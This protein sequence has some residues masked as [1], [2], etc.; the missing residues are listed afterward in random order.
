MEL[1]FD[2]QQTKKN[3]TVF[4]K[5]ANKV[6]VLYYSSLALKSHSRYSDTPVYAQGQ[7][8][9][10]VA[11]AALLRIEAQEEW[12]EIETALELMEP[13]NKLLIAKKYLTSDKLSDTNV[14][15][16]LNLSSSHFY[17]K[18][19]KALIEFAFCYRGGELV[20]WE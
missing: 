15:T 10:Q 20:A 7:H 8:S 11:K 1:N 19:E 6:R 4:L 18:L 12:A 14:Y 3:V 9:E 5:H 2:H 16:T 17:R 13:E